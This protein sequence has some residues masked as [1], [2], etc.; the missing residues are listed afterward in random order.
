MT[1]KRL[2]KFVQATD[3]I[4]PRFGLFIVNELIKKAQL[5]EHI[6]KTFGKPGSNRGYK[7]SEYVHTL[8]SLLHDGAV[9][10]EDVVHLYSD[11]V[12]QELVSH[13]RLPSSDAL[14]DWLRRQG[15]LQGEAKMRLVN[16]HLFS[17]ALETGN[18]VT[19]DID[20]TIVRA[21]KGDAQRSYNG[22]RGYQP[23]L[24]IVEETGIVAGCDFRQGNVSP[25]SNLWDFVL[26]CQTTY[27]QTITTIRSDSAGYQKELIEQCMEHKKYF[28][29]TAKQTTGVL[30]ALE[31]IPEEQWQQGIYPDG[32]R[33]NYQVAETSYTFSSRKKSFR[34]VA[35]RYDI[36]PQGDLFASHKYWVVVTNIPHEQANT[37][38]AILFHAHRGE[39][40]RVIGEIKHQFGLQHVPCGQFNA[41]ALFFAIGI[42]AYNLLQI[43][44]LISFT[45]EK[46]KSSVRSLRY[47]LIHLA[48]K[49]V[50]HARYTI[51]HIAAPLR[52][53]KLFERLF[54]RLNLAPW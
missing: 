53:V 49:I 21:E 46:R 11:P 27:G 37:H 6:D 30:S 13:N 50:F 40:E 23:L 10:L 24:G 52:N 47:Q 28:S 3:K 16:Q 34:L 14:G 51:L 20:A 17:V 22:T 39:M 54:L 33:A 41:N 43:I 36:G 5:N 32:L 42:F 31:A 7:A 25:A 45:P 1:Q 12:Y 35:K 4:T 2:Y 48:G 8:V 29:I 44:K 9:H 18:H 15:D 38:Q 19:L 26:Q